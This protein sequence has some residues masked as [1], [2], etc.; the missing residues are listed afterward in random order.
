MN[1]HRTLLS[2]DRKAQKAFYQNYKVSMFKLCRLYIQDRQ[3]AEDALQEGFISVFK[4]LPTYDSDK[5]SLETWMR[6][7]FTNACLKQIRK[8]QSRIQT[9]SLTHVISDLQNSVDTIRLS[10]LSLKEIYLLLDKLPEGYRKVF[11]LYFVEGY[12]H[13]EISHLLNISE[14]TS[15]SQL[16]KSKMK[17]QDLIIEKFPNQYSQYA[18]T[19]HG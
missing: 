19:S 4:S 6:K 2:G 7:I 16:R 3:G 18:N 10:N 12:T 8:T 9:T 14:N 17:M 1:D 13:Q 15:K 5:G 11:V